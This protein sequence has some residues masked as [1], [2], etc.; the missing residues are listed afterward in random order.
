MSNEAERLNDL[1]PGIGEGLALPGPQSGQ[2]SAVSPSPCDQGEE[3]D[4]AIVHVRQGQR[5]NLRVVLCNAPFRVR[6]FRN[7]TVIF[8]EEN[9]RDE[10]NVPIE[11]LTAGGHSLVWAFLAAGTPW[12]TRSEV[13]VDDNL[14]FCLKKGTDSSIPSNQL[15]IFLQ[16]T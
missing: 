10:V 1:L 15:V 2:G 6:V 12:K 7:Q 16:V 4:V 3:R 8:D 9:L 11:G 14:E 5:V 13:T